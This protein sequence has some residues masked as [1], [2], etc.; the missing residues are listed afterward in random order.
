IIKVLSGAAI[1]LTVQSSLRV[2]NDMETNVGCDMS[3]GA[4]IQPVFLVG[5][6][7]TSWPPSRLCSAVLRVLGGL[8]TY[9]AINLPNL[10]I[11]P[12]L[13]LSSLSCHLNHRFREVPAQETA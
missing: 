8:C 3:E 6:L 10:S 1:G 11:H 13:T 5:G 4:I 2:G 7:L 12:P 9:L